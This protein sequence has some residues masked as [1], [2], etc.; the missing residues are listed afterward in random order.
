MLHSRIHLIKF[1]TKIGC[2]VYVKRDDE[3]GFGITGTKFRK[4]HSLLPYLQ[5]RNIKNAILIG[6]AYSNNIVSLVQLLIENHIVPYL[7]LRGE[8]PK[9]VTGNFLLVSLFVTKERIFWID[10]KSW[11]NAEQIAQKF[12]NTLSDTSILIPEGT[13]RMEALPG[14][15]TLGED[16][17][18]NEQ[19]A[20]LTFDHIFIESGT[21]LAAIGL[22]LGL[23][24]LKRYPN[25][26]ILLVAGN[27]AEFLEK[28][29][30]CY[31]WQEGVATGKINLPEIT[32][33]IHFYYPIIGKSFGSIN[34]ETFET[35]LQI[36][37]TDGIITDPIYSAKL[38]MATKH[39]I[40]STSILGNLLIV[41]S[42]GGLGLFG[43]Q[44][45]IETYLL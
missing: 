36:A 43:Y 20:K 3:L 2:K 23:H 17:F 9:S 13:Y 16:I 32:K 38:F 40:N 12:V 37:R 6:G 39:I 11:E 8:E 10:R 24:K 25:I 19:E 44:K 33:N 14:A 27:E 1:V 7:F 22:V 45:L 35:I 15:C 34:K 29:A 28:L 5:Q 41:H 4:Y 42:G 21:G 26:H 18:K 31:T 30:H